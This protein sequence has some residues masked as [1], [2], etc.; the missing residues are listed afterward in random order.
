VPKHNLSSSAPD[1]IDLCIADQRSTLSKSGEQAQVSRH[2]PIPRP[3]QQPNGAAE[4][5]AIVRAQE[6]CAFDRSL[7][8]NEGRRQLQQDGSAMVLPTWD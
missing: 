3:A 6:A 4:S 1:V 7:E 8:G 2:Q 5:R